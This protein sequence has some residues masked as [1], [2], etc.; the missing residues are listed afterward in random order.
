M[1]KTRTKLPEA[2]TYPKTDSRFWRNRLF[3]RTT[4]EWQVQ[5]GY[6]GRQERFPLKTANQDQAAVKSRDIYLSLLR[7]GWEATLAKF[8]PWTVEAAKAD[9]EV[10][11][12]DYITSAKAVSEVGATTFTSYERKFRFLVSQIMA[13]QGT[14]ARHDYVHGGSQKWRGEVDAVPLAKITPDEVARWRVRYVTEHGGNP[15]KEN[16]ARQTVASIIRNAK[17]LFSPKILQHVG[18]ELPKPLPFEGVTPGK[19]PRTRYKSKINPALIV[20]LAHKELKQ[21]Q[22]E[23]FKIFLLAFGAGLRRGEIDRLTWKQ[24]DWNKSTLSL[25]VTE[26][27]DLKTDGSAEEIDISD[28]MLAYFKAQLAES[29][30][31]FVISSAVEVSQPKHWNHYRCDRH[32][33][34]LIDWLHDHHVEARNP[35]H[36]LRKEFGSLINQQF[37]IYAASAALRHSNI[38]LT[39]EYYVDKKERIALDLTQLVKDQKGA[40]HAA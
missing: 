32:F 24:F 27:G 5:I 31:P 9:S 14:K 12:G 7:E 18:L 22:P 35:L 39:R 17:S 13:V 33:K 29:T 11:V 16:S 4:D 3:K 37:G 21:A 19:T 30:S 6:A 26:Y 36:T 2:K 25:E 15:L 8:K 23:L 10:T 40:A 38:N 20:Q 1:N 28:D 34:D